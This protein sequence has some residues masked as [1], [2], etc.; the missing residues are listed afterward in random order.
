M[1][2]M[3][4]IE[5]AR[6]RLKLPMHIPSAEIVRVVAGTGLHARIQMY[7]A[8]QKLKAALVG[9][10]TPVDFRQSNGT[11]RGNAETKDLPVCRTAEGTTCSCWKV[12]FWKRLRL[13]V[14]GRIWLVVKGNTQPPLWIDTEVFWK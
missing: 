7:L 13:L 11:L 12:S 5:E 14:N 8:V 1:M 10:V 2:R 6:R 4:E 9:E 3:S